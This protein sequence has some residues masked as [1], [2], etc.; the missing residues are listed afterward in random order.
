MPRGKVAEV[1]D[2]MVNANG[3]H[4]TRTEEGWRFTHHLI[5]EQ[6]LGRRLQGEQVRFKDKDK[7]NLHPDNIEIVPLGK[8]SIRKRLATLEAK[9]ADLTAE[10]DILLKELDG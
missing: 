1:G 7:T 2:V 8:S 3:Y 10:R 5:A 9:I 4:N 6:K